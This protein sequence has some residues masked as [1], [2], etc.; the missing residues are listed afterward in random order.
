MKKIFIKLFILTAPLFF[1]T[2]C[3]L[4]EHPMSVLSP[5]GYYQTQKGIES[6]VNGIY[7]VSRNL[8]KIP[9]PLHRI[10]VFGTDT[11]QAAE[12]FDTRS[13]NWYVVT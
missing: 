8:E 2:T 13:L 1:F 4:E 10:N 9:D 7:Q 3:D 5:G 12:A 6:L 11:E